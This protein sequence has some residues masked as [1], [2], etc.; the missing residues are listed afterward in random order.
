MGRTAR[1]GEELHEDK[2]NQM[3]TEVTLIK[4]EVNK[5]MF[6]KSLRRKDSLTS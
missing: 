2:S 5:R 1:T 4:E 3:C 6:T